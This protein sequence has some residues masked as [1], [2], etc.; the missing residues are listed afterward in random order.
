ML[1]C[2]ILALLLLIQPILTANSQVLIGE[3]PLYLTDRLP[4]GELKQRLQECSLS[5]IQVQNFSIAHRGASLMYPE[6][7]EAAYLAAI[8]QGA[9]IIECDV[10]F[11]QDKQLVCRHAQCDLHH[12]TD[13]LLR[14]ELASRC[15]TSFTS[16]DAKTNAAATAKCCASDFTLEEIQ[17]LC[18]VMEGYDER[19]TNPESF[20]R[21]G[22]NWRTQLHAQCES[23]VS[24]DESIALFDA[25]DRMMTPEL[26][27]PVVDMPFAGFSRADFA[28]AIVQA[29]VDFDISPERV[30]LQ[31]FHLEDIQHWIKHWPDFAQ[32]A[33]WLDGRYTLANFD[34]NNPETWQVSMQALYDMGVRYLGPPLWMLVRADGQKIRPSIYAK[35]ATEAGLNLIAWTVE[36]S[37]SLHD[38]G[39]WYYQS[40][41]DITTDAHVVLQLLEVLKHDIGVKAVFSDWPATTTY[42]AHC[43]SE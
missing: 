23:P 21:G 7:S 11:T 33:I 3:R 25:H 19:A 13:I 31:S 32:Q 4:E 17:S 43:T 9:G 27:A 10:T 34:P 28:D 20:L 6:H 42:F 24:H 1:R 22:P 29:Y 40:I 35:Q 38:G 39:G 30:F 5:D 16:Y 2:A 12:T 41:A 18:A 14:P 8:R 15:Q 26:K 36:R 37:G